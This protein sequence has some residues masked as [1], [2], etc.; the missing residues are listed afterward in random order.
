MHR[1]GDIAN[2]R[3]LRGTR[4]WFEP[5]ACVRMCLYIHVCLFWKRPFVELAG[6]CWSVQRLRLILESWW[7]KN[8]RSYCLS[9]P[10]NT[11]PARLVPTVENPCAYVFAPIL[12]IQHVWMHVTTYIFLSIFLA[13]A[14]EEGKWCIISG[15]EINQRGRS[16]NA[17]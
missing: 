9:I 3:K 12:H 8:C 4:L 16:E 5:D 1:S 7:C 10:L 6:Q 14:G 15:G 13:R 11:S 2:E 17:W